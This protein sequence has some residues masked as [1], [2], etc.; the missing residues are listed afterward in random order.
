M[1]RRSPLFAA[2]E[3]DA[4][5][6]ILDAARDVVAE[7]GLSQLSLRGVAERA[8]VS[9]GS[10]SYRIGDRAALVTAIARREGERA[11]AHCR[12]WELRIGAVAAGDRDCLADVVAAWLRHGAGHGRRSAVVQAEL[13]SA[14]YRD[15]A[16]LP[17]VRAITARHTAMWRQILADWAEPE[18]LARRIASYC[19]DERPFSIL[20]QDSVDYALL[21]ASTVRGL[22][23]TPDAMAAQ[24]HSDWHMRVVTLLEALAR[25]AF[26]AGDPPRGAKAAIAE[27]IADLIMANGLEWLSHRMI[28][29]A[30]GMPLSSVAHHFPTQR[31]ILIGGVEALYL[32][33]QAEV[34]DPQREAPGVRTAGSAVVALGHEMALGALREPAFLPFAVDMRRRRAE[35]VY[36][37]I[38][39]MLGCGE[40]IDRALTQ[41]CVMALI[42]MRLGGLTLDWHGSDFQT[43]LQTI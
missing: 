2:P 41:G 1:S 21:R 23:R 28:A 35:N 26:D 20:L 15:G 5:T 8:G 10:I 40:V 4:N 22:L 43:L 16:L 37:M 14:G 39:P 29:Q 33:L 18:R 9:V 19:V 42:G 17:A 3:S 12:A 30:I 36:A 32:R 11:E 27:R 25:A 13:V 24:A 6:L 38:G 34:R 31:D 7:R